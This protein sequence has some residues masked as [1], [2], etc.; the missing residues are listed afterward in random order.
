MPN[1]DTIF[2]VA[3]RRLPAEG[4]DCLLIGGFAV[5]YHG[6]TRNTLDVDFMVVAGQADIVRRAMADAGFTNVV[7][8]DNVTLFRAP[9]CS[10]RAD[11]LHV[12][13]ET[14]QKLL[15]NALTAEVHGHRLKIPA[16]RDLLA[17][18]IF[19]LSNQP[20]RRMAKDLPDIAWLSVLHDLDMDA[21]VRPLCDRFGTPEVNELIRQHIAELRSP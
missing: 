18:K 4:V 14:L 9:D 1:L 3:S 19:A 20:T 15:S 17:M 11:F 10:L 6:Y 7:V 8:E 16:L 2:D 12:D 13:E 5:N 21:D